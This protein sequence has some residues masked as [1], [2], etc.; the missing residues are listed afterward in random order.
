[1]V[2][3]NLFLTLANRSFDYAFHRTLF[4]KNNMLPFILA[5]SVGM[6]VAILYVPF[7]SQLFKMG[8]ISAGDL[9]WCVLAG[10]LS[11]V[12]FEVYKAIREWVT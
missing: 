10:S 11:V 8:A 1:L 3:A 9:G 4:Y 12:W 5:I 7:L 6:L 2:T